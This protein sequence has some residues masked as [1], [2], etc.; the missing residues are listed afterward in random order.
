MSAVQ[1]TVLAAVAVLPA[2]SVAVHVLVCDIV[3][4]PVGSLSLDVIEADP[5]SSVAVAEPSAASISDASGLQPNVSVVPVAVI[6]GGSF[7]STV[8]AIVSV[9]NG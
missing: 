7:P 9:V 2:T 6:S 1:V 3:Q 8:I 5:Q 4:V